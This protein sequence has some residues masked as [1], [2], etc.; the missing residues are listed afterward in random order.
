MPRRQ[1]RRSHPQLD[2]G[3]LAATLETS[4]HR[5]TLLL[6]G[7]GSRVT[8][9]TDLTWT[10]PETELDPWPG[11]GPVPVTDTVVLETKSGSAP[12]A[13]DRLLWKRGQRPSRISKFG[14]GLAALTPELPAHR[15]NR[16]L[17]THLTTARP[18]ERT[19]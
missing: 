1:R 14:T 2:T 4:Y 19:P 12:C 3:R 9:D 8:V 6:P 16:V 17:R 5:A 11:T 15:W 10:L 7:S 13:A 18:H